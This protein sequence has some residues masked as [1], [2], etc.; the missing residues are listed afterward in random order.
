MRSTIVEVHDDDGVQTTRT[1]VDARR[2]LLRGTVL[3]IIGA[4]ILALISGIYT[5]MGIGMLII[6]IVFAGVTSVIGE[7]IVGTAAM[8]A[9]WFPAFAVTLIFLMMGMFIGFPTVAL[10]VMLGYQVCIGPA[11][12]D[13]GYDL[14]AGWILRGKGKNHNFELS[15]RKSQFKAN[16][17]GIFVGIVIV[18]FGYR[19]YFMQDLFPPMAR[20]FIATIEAGANPEILRSLAMWAAVGAIVQA[21]GGTKRQMG[22]MLSTGLLIFNQFG[23]FVALAVIAIRVVLEKI[24]GDKINNTIYTA[25]AGLIVGS[26]MYGFITNSIS[27]FGR[28]N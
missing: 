20:V 5:Q 12:A 9:G 24:Y 13:M 15:G 4:V 17:I 22:V 6:W 27:A 10:V 16:L 8:H 11:F 2:A 26:S 23:G 18:F 28:R 21:I 19:A 3:F 25:A 1:A 7:L 14:K